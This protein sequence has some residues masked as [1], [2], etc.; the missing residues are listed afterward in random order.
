MPFEVPK[1]K[2]SLKQNRFEFNFPGEKKTYSLPLIKFLPPWLALRF[3]E[4]TDVDEQTFRDLFDVIAPGE[5]LFAKFDD[6]EQFEAFMSAW[7]EASGVTL[8]ESEAS[9]EN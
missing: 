9:A 4:A 2:A 6:S 5:D 3:K 1:S 8:G 7:G